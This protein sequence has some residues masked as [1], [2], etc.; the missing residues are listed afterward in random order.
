MPTL[1]HVNRCA[2]RIVP[3]EP[4]RAWAASLPGDSNPTDDV[5]NE[6]TIYLLPDCDDDP[7]FERAMKRLYPIIFEY[8]LMSW[9]TNEDDWPDQ[10]DYKTFRAWFDIQFSSEVIDLGGKALMSEDLG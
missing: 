7:A 1:R 8:E 6:Q 4:Y 2:V 10:R 9:W 5:G 3:K